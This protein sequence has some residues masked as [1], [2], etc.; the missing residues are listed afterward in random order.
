MIQELQLTRINSARAVVFFIWLNM[1][2]VGL[3]QTP[4]SSTKPLIS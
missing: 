2:A 4:A 3:K 1:Y